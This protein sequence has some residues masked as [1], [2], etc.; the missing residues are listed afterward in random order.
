MALRFFSAFARVAFPSGEAEHRRVKEIL[1]SAKT[2]KGPYRYFN[3]DLA[4]TMIAD[5]IQEHISGRNL[6]PWPNGLQGRREDDQ[7]KAADFSRHFDL[8]QASCSSISGFALRGCAVEGGGGLD[9]IAQP[10][11]QGGAG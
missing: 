6:I 1:F 7:L 2:S 3:E 9:R 4:E 10:V 8:P 5:A 11:P